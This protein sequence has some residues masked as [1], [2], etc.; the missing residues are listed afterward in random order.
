MVYHNK[1][2]RFI[3]SFI[4]I[5]LILACVLPFILLISSS[6]TSE[7]ALALEGY[8]FIPS[9]I[10]LAAYRYIWGIK[11]NILRAYGMSFLVTGVGTV[12]SIIMTMLFAYP[13][14][15]K[16]LPGRRF[17][18]FFIFFTMLFNGGFVP[19]YL[20]YSQIFHISDTVWALIVPYLLM[21]AFFVIMVRTYITSNV[22]DEVI[23]A[24]TI[25]GSGEFNTLVKVVVPMSKPIIGTIALM[26][27]ISYW[28]NWTN[29]VYFIQIR[30]ELYGIQN[31][32]NSVISNVSFLQSHSN[33]NIDIRDLPSVSIRMALAVI[34]LLPILCAYPFFQ[35]SFAKGITVGSVKG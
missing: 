25:D 22:P 35:K 8:S 28:N 4:M 30:R 10:S 7:Q 33:P 21:N 24:A 23:E 29:G 2:F 9:E 27:A 1:V 34:A 19:T 12:I 17:L 32:L 5:L 18:S 26:T 16:D 6:F 11:E 13:L 3:M 20:I 31:Y 15:R 14:S